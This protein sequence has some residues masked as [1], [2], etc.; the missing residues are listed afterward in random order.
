MS[1]DNEGR[2][3]G[4]VIYILESHVHCV[5][6][7]VLQYLNLISKGADS[8]LQKVKMNGRHLGAEKGVILLH[9]L[10]EHYPVIGAGHHPALKMS[11]VPYLYGCNEGADSYSGRSQVIDLVNL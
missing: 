5:S 7:V 4:V 6:V 3:A 2:V 11:L 10:G 9:L 8:R 1:D